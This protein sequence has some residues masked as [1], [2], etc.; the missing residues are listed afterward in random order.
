M[1]KLEWMRVGKNGLRL[2]MQGKQRMGI[3]KRVLFVLLLPV[4]SS[5]A[6]EQAK[7]KLES[8]ETCKEC[9][10]Q[11][12][13]EWAN[14]GHAHFSREQ[15]LPFVRLSGRV[16]AGKRDISHCQGCHEPLRQFSDSVSDSKII[17]RERVTCDFCH[18]VQIDHPRQK[19]TLHPSG[20]KQGPIEKTESPKHKVA[21]SREITSSDF[22]LV[23]HHKSRDDH[24]QLRKEFPPELINCQS[25]HMPLR[26]DGSKGHSHAFPGRF[27]EEMLQ[28]AFE[29]DVVVQEVDAG[30]QVDVKLTNIV[31]AHSVPPAPAGYSYIVL[32]VTAQDVSNKV[33][34]KNWDVKP[35]DEPI[36]ATIH[37]DSRGV[38]PQAIYVKAKE[39]KGF[40]YLLKDKTIRWVE[41]RLVSYALAPREVARMKLKDPFYTRGR[42]MAFRRLC[43]GNDN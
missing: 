14:S 29:F 1:A 10:K 40:Q 31:N 37:A 24:R 2:N 18:S 32:W 7:P 22:C 4:L 38:V 41:A 21:Y 11:H 6:Q 15:N 27:S 28:K 33:V 9:H 5:S 19:F 43:L 12:Y 23:C 25:C 16:G 3:F 8:A 35:S 20:A 17:V 39:S 26:R 13:M 42:T 30:L 36:L 34:W